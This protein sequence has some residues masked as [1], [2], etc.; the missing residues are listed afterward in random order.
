MG[1]TIIADDSNRT[2]LRIFLYL[3][4]KMIDKRILMATMAT[5]GTLAFSGG[6]HSNRQRQL[7][8]GLPKPTQH[9]QAVRLL[10]L[11]QPILPIW[12]I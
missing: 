4:A 10:I 6:K 5:P 8:V 2:R 3:R 11:P 9:T 1:A 12:I 7:R